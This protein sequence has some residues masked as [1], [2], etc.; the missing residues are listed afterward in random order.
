MKRVVQ[1]GFGRL[2]FLTLAVVSGCYSG[3]AGLP[4][5]SDNDCDKMKCIAQVCGGTGPTSGAAGTMDS[6]ASD[7]TATATSTSGTSSSASTSGDVS[8]SGSTSEASTGGGVSTTSSS[9]TSDGTS[10]T[11]DVPTDCGNGILDPEEECD[12]GNLD[13]VDGCEPDCKR[14]IV[15]IQA[16]LAHT[17]VLLVDGSLRCWGNNSNGELGRGDVEN[18]GDE[19]GEM[20][21]GAVDVGGEVSDLSVGVEHVCVIVDGAVRCWGRNQPGTL[22][23]GHI[24][25]IGDNPGEM[26]PDDVLLGGDV[27]HVSAGYSHTCARLGDGS[28]RCWGENGAG[29]LGVGSTEDLGDA[30]GEMP[31]PAVALGGVPQALSLGSTYSCA[32]MNGGVLRCWGD[33]WAAALGHSYPEDVGDQPGEM[34]PPNSVVGASVVDVSTR[35]S[36][37]ICALVDQGEVRCWGANWYNA[38]GRGNGGAVECQGNLC[39]AGENCCVGDDPGEMPP[40]YV[41]VGGGASCVVMG[42]YHACAIMVDGGVRCWGQGGYGRLGNG[43][44]ESV[45][46][47]PGEMPPPNVP[48]GG[49]RVVDVAVG[50]LHTCALV[51]SGDVFCWGQNS[52]GQLG[53]GTTESIGD[54]PGEMPP[55]PVKIF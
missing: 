44:N 29:Q 3:T 2:A 14:T 20:P 27:E 37:S 10:S 13:G 42:Y 9:S 21:P 18:I 15:A 41:D 43:S 49:A 8:A 17:C 36:N 28:V 38:L 33:N 55:P 51:E 32:R 30:P 23:Y 46:D 1:T 19:P 54:E 6:S 26:P 45:G 52:A 47:E 22:G 31:P 11:G 5:E 25:N 40:L 16:G 24:N 34:P 12:D 48:L 53:L 35:G 50:F 39:G 7:S 4:C